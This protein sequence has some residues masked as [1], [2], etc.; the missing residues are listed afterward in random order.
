MVRGCLVAHLMKSQ[1][2]HSSKYYHPLPFQTQQ[3]VSAH[4][5]LINHI[6][7]LRKCQPRTTVTGH[8][9]RTAAILINTLPQ[10]LHTVSE[11][12]QRTSVSWNR[13]KGQTLEKLF[14]IYFLQICNPITARLEINSKYHRNLLE[15]WPG[16][17]YTCSSLGCAIFW[18]LS[19]VATMIDIMLQPFWFVEQL[20]FR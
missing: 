4:F 3:I 13:V 14:C 18:F 11:A 5:S 15:M 7:T 9:G 6:H 19:I 16:S 1:A 10:T 17:C 12:Q 2:D 8:Q 20:W